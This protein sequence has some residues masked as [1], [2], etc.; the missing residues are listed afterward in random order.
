MF[1]IMC[2]FWCTC[3]ASGISLQKA[4]AEIS[5]YQIFSVHWFV[6][7]TGSYTISSKVNIQTSHSRTIVIFFY[8]KKLLCH[9]EDFVQEDIV[10]FILCALKLFK[11]LPLSANYTQSHT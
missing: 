6:F 11:L 10:V 4:R 2:F 5:G 3:V 7:I 8:L 9:A 1:L